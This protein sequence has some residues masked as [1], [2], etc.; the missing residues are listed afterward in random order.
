MW[1]GSVTAISCLVV[2]MNSAYAAATPTTPS[3][4]TR[5]DGSTS[6]AKTPTQNGA[7]DGV[8]TTRPYVNETHDLRGNDTTVNYPY[9]VCMALSTDLVRFGKTIECAA[10][11][12]KTP[13]EEGIMVVYKIDIIPH[14]FKVLTYYKNLR[15]QRSYT[16]FYEYF[17]LGTSVTKLA[18]PSYEIDLIN[19]DGNC[20]S[21]VS[22]EMSGRTYISYH[23]DVEEN[24][25]MSLMLDDYSSVS[26]VRYVTTKEFE[27]KPTTT[28]L[29]KESCAINCIVTIT[30]ARSK[31]PYDFFVLSSGEVVEI[32]PFYNGSNEERF[33]ENT[34]MFW[35]RQNYT[36]REHFG[37]QDDDVGKRKVRMM[38]FLEKPDMTIAWEVHDKKNVTCTWKRWQTV[39]KAIRTDQGNSFHFASKS[40]TATFV[41]GKQN[42][43]YNASG[44]EYTCVKEEFLQEIERVYQE[45]YNETHDKIGYPEMY[46]TNAGLLVFWQRISPKSLQALEGFANNISAGNVSA[47]G[48]SHTRRRRSLDVDNVS[49]DISYAQLQFTYDVLREYINQ[50]L[51][52]ILD[53]WCL[54]Q[55]R[56]AEVL[57][58]LSKINPSNILSAVYD[59]PVTARLAG[60]VIA[61]SSCIEVDQNS[62]KILKDMRIF[63]GDKV[64]NCYSRPQVLFSFVNSTKVE[65]GQLG[66]NNE[67]LL[68]TFRT[69]ECESPSRKI[70]VAGKVGYEYR[71]YVFKN[72]TDLDSIEL[73]DTMIKLDIEPLEN[74]DFNLLE[75]YS[76]GEIKSSNVFNLEDIM[77]EYNSQKQSVHFLISKVNDRTPAYLVGLD[78]FLQGLGFAGKGLGAVLG[79][80]GGA[81]SSFVDAVASFLKNP[82]GGLL[83]ILLAVGVVLII[84]MLVR[85]QQAAAR[86]PV[87]YFFPYATKTEDSG[88]DVT[89]ADK[90]PPYEDVPKKSG[91]I[92]DGGGDVRNKD[93]KGGGVKSYSEGE[94]LQ[95]LKALQRL[96]EN[97][98]NA[99][100]SKKSKPDSGI[101]SRLRKKRGYERVNQSSDVED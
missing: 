65:T 57:K 81:V 5:V 33:E 45:E 42:V 36:M 19:K 67:I 86:R 58:E 52:N 75:L 10:H 56:T 1:T 68:G 83:M 92:G 20:Y 21:A 24:K 14:T 48:T 82:F 35:I 49:T 88:G 2:F 69:E 39:N 91:V 63:D 72:V 30:R 9:R 15:F 8:T 87:E 47:N 66:E 38:A 101:L 54:D 40:L 12:P 17:L 60:D 22:R 80:V 84:W 78:R 62:V 70:F 28:F 94:A 25:T 97:K 90:P 100:S 7:T 4:S 41:T 31:I 98:R 43:S 96:D 51:R 16:G 71:E 44:S 32:S 11:T 59:K 74:T 55:K 95:M 93:K 13:I 53:A 23:N 89:S 79:A 73:I 61:M 26:S 64:V 34:A 3:P 29:Y 85:R 50:A 27:H 37:D 46:I 76:R 99:S 6:G 18:I 77:R